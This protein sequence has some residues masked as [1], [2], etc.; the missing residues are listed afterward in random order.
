MK[1]RIGFLII[2]FTFH[3]LSDFVIKKEHKKI[4]IEGQ[5]K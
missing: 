5:K 1:V 4:N 3:S 2:L